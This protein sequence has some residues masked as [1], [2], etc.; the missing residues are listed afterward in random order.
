MLSVASSAAAQEQVTL[1]ADN[2]PKGVFAEFK[3]SSGTTPFSSRVTF[4]NDFSGEGGTYPISVVGNAPSGSRSYKMNV[5]LDYYKGWRFD[6]TVYTQRMVE[7]YAGSATRYPYIKV[8]GGGAGILTISFGLGKSLPRA[9]RTYKITPFSGTT[10]D[11]QVTMFDDPVIYGATGVGSPTGTF[12]FDSLGK[13]TFKCTGVEM[14]DGVRK[15][16]LDAS[17]SE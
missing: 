15:R 1:Y 17:F 3:P 10:D 8:Y 5:K 13:F 9:N 14:S 7:K 11:I 6:D 2:L 12:T 16:T 4:W